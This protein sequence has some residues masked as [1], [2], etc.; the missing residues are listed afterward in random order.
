M[1]IK[2]VD[3]RAET[4]PIDDIADRTAD[5]EAD[6]GAKKACANPAE[7]DDQDEDDRQG[8]ER[9]DQRIDPVAVEQAKADPGVAGQHEVEK[10]ADRDTVEGAAGLAEKRQH[11]RLARLIEHRGRRRHGEPAPEHHPANGAMAPRSR[12]SAQRRQRSSC[13]GTWPTSGNTRQQR[14]QRSPAAGM[15]TTAIPGASGS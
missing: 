4:Q 9:K 2:K 6:R 13:P 14:S 10:R 15:T 5:D 3:D 12:T 11:H 7:P 8:G 1:K